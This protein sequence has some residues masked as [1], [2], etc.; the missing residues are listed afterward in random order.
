M[1]L[2]RGEAAD[3]EAIG[4][5]HRHTIRTSLPFLPDIHTVSEVIA[6]V[7]RDLLP[8]NEIWVA[9]DG[10]RTLGYIA[11]DAVWINQL[12][13]HPDAQGQGIGPALLAKALADGRSRR[14]WTFQQNTRARKFYEDRGF[15]LVELTDGSGNEEKAPDVLYEWRP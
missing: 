7:G 3:A 2:R 11:F 14:L 1:N 9:E 13:V 10:G 15:V 6:Y 8:N 12:Y 5:L 4:T